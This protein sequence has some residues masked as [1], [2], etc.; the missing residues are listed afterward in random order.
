MRAAKARARSTILCLSHHS[1]TETYAP[2]HTCTHMPHITTHI[3][4]DS[5]AGWPHNTTTK[6]K[7]SGLTPRMCSRASPS[8]LT[9]RMC[10]RAS[11]SRPRARS[12]SVAR[13]LE[14]RAKA[15]ARSTTR[16][17]KRKFRAVISYHVK[18]AGRAGRG[19]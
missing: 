8:G 16:T 19:R 18:D 15:R 11:P 13:D 5:Q 7:P 10:S 4:Q 9:P 1:L 14:S 3:A 12:C 2:L 17:Y 6:C